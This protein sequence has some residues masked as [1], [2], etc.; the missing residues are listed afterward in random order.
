[1]NPG[2]LQFWNLLKRLQERGQTK[3]RF[4]STNGGFPPRTQN[5]LVMLTPLVQDGKAARYYP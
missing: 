2:E 4:L 1:M 5:T 3:A